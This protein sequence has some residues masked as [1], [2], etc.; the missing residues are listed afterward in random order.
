MANNKYQMNSL[1]SKY[2][3]V[4]MAMNQVSDIKLALAVRHAGA[5][6]SLSGFNY[7]NIDQLESDFKTYQQQ[8][9]DGLL[10]FSTS[11]NRLMDLEILNLV[12]QYKIQ[13][14]E[15]IYDPE[16]D[17]VTV[18][19]KDNLFSI[20]T[21]HNIKI[22][23]KCLGGSDIVSGITGVVLKGNEGAGRGR[24]PTSKLF[25][26]IQL[27]FPHLLIIVSGGVS[28]ADQVK[29]YIDR[30]AIAVGVG[31]LI[32]ACQ[33]S[34]ISVETKRKMIESST[35]NLTR[36]PDQ[37]GQQALVF[38]EYNNDDANHTHSLS[39]GITDPSSGHVFAGTAIDSITEILPVDAIIKS[40][41][42]KL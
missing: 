37:A 27:K 25:E 42:A 28:N 39:A 38:D 2:P 8:F 1:G 35:S 31:T 9:N 29:Y 6:P 33:E 22:F 30:G 17:L 23:T 24:Y 13:M 41:V 16:H 10:L 4:A 11:V 3:I 36:F 34:K 32:S 15:L 7:S 21:Q 19:Q 14:V 18:D 26:H 5:I 40:L 12:L 20:L